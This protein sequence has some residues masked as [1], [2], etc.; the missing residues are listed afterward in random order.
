MTDAVRQLEALKQRVAQINTRIARAEALRQVAARNHES[1]KL[2][3][4][5][6]F[7]TADPDALEKLAESARKDAEALIAQTSAALDEAE[8]QLTVAEKALQQ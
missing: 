7:G 6:E 3:A 5:L 1:A 4:E 8:R 2:E